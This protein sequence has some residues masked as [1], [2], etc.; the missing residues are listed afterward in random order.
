MG[1]KL[2]NTSKIPEMHPKYDIFFFFLER[3]KYDIFDVYT[4]L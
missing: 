2:D 1:E 3:W 4:K